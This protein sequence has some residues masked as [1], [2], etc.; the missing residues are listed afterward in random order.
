MAFFTSFTFAKPFEF[1]SIT[2]FVLFTKNKELWNEGKDDF[3]HIWLFQHITSYQRRLN[4]WG[5]KGIPFSVKIHFLDTHV[6]I[7]NPY[8]QSSGVI[9]F[10]CK[11]YLVISDKLIDSFL[12]VF[13]LLLAV[14][15]SELHEKP[16]RKDWVTEKIT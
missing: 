16:R 14:L 2:F 5:W 12:D 7:N 13:Y 3:L 9:I 1:Y 10:F 11:Y 4:H 6:C 8:W 15:L